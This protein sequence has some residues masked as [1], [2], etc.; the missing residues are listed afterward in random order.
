MR[1]APSDHDTCWRR[2]VWSACGLVRKRFTLD[3]AVLQVLVPL[4]GV[5]TR[6]TLNTVGASHISHATS[7]LDVL[8]A[9]PSQDYYSLKLWPLP[10]D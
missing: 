9:Q 6:N 2:V 8:L 4:L 10:L 7:Y 5:Q 3:T 1:M